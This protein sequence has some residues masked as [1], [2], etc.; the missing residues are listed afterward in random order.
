[1]HGGEVTADSEGKGKGATFRF[2][3]PVTDARQAEAAPQGVLP[4][5]DARRILVVDDTKEALEMFV[6]FLRAA[7]ATVF[8]AASMSEALDTC[9]REEIDAI[10]TD[11]AMPGGDG[12][13]LITTLRNHAGSKH[14]SIVAMTALGSSMREASLNAG[15]DAFMEKPVAPSDLVRVLAEL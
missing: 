10:V 4:H 9:A 3:L 7:G 8:S 14:F 13:E 1:L 5:L 12:I 2:M 11:L 6:S 15:A